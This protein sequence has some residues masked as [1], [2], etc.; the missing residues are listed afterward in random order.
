MSDAVTWLI[1]LGNMTAESDEWTV[2]FA[3]T[4]NGSVRPTS[5]ISKVDKIPSQD[6]L[7]GLT[8]SAVA[9]F[10]AKAEAAKSD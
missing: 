2:L 6:E 9:A 5:I 7:A 1:D 3:G 10:M 8:E 4:L